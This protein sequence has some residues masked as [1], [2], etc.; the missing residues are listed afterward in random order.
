[1]DGIW[2]DLRAEGAGRARTHK[3]EEGMVGRGKR[4]EE[5]RAG[6]EEHARTALYCR[7][8]RHFKTA[9]IFQNA[10]CDRWE[11]PRKQSCR[12]IRRCSFLRSLVSCSR[13]ELGRPGISEPFSLHYIILHTVV[14]LHFFLF[15]MV[16]WLKHR[17]YIGAY[18]TIR[19][20][21][22]RDMAAGPDF[23]SHVQMADR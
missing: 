17:A 11:D 9:M 10:S 6:T 2:S 12:H 1:M 8:V 21:G 19:P 4:M 18:C 22:E 16:V 5:A 20:P 23:L 13:A 15:G 3:R 7:A 14:Q